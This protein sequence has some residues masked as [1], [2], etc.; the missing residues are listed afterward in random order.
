MRE[1]RNLRTCQLVNVCDFSC[2]PYCCLLFSISER[3]QIESDDG[4][5]TEEAN[6]GVTE[7]E[8]KGVTEEEDE[9][10]T[11]EQPKKKARREF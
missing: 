10:V 7:E 5:V 3:S 11:E 8:D 6:E 9:G 2:V 4:G 1:E